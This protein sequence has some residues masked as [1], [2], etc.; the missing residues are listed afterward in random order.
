MQFNN[1]IL[2]L[3]TVLL[4]SILKYFGNKKFSEKKKVNISGRDKQIWI[5]WK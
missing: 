5:K 4:S 1:N 2:F 3:I